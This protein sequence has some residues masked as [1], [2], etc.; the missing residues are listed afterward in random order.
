MSI[1]TTCKYVTELEGYGLIRAERTTVATQNG[2]TLSSC[3]CYYVLPIQISI[4]QFH[5]RQLH[6]AGLA[7]ER[8]KAERR[9][10]TLEEKECA[11]GY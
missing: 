8:Q 1:N 6:A 11:S 3:L 2:R 7:L 4:G 5:T 9:M 10:A